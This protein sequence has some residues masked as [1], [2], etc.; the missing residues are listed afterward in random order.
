M[1]TAETLQ[2]PS[3]QPRWPY[4]AAS[5]IFGGLLFWF[6][7]WLAVRPPDPLGPLSLQ[8]QNEFHWGAVAK[9]IV[10][11]AVTAAG[12]GALFGRRVPI[13][14]AF[15]VAFGLMV[16]TLRTDG[17]RPLLVS[18]LGADGVE[19][20]A[21]YFRLAVESIQWFA[22]VLVGLL[23]GQMAESWLGLESDRL[24][25]EDASNR[26]KRS[27]SPSRK[28]GQVGRFWEPWTLQRDDWLLGMMA[29]GLTA[30]ISG[31]LLWMFC[32]TGDK[33]Q[34]CFGLLASFSIASTLS[35]QICR[36]KLGVWH[37]ASAP[38]TAIAAYLWAAAQSGVGLYDLPTEPPS[39]LCRPLPAEFMSWGIAGS[40]IGFWYSQ[41]R[42]KQTKSEGPGT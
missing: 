20:S 40:I 35:H 6:V 27:T 38:L 30:V 42:L 14:G 11:A 5:C 7:G 34:V 25:R 32:K 2:D 22:L 3:E 29:T 9:L 33:G 36:T 12:A 41:G 21:I 39:P 10:V 24:P 17:I 18:R 13:I 4:I 23:S 26:E 37:I 19:N 8:S 1:E 16:L 15:A 31:L 28:K